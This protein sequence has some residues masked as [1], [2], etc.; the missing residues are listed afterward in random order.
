[1]ELP[2]VGIP[3]V[4]HPCQKLGSA[5]LGNENT[6]QQQQVENLTRGEREEH[7]RD[8]LILG[9]LLGILIRLIYRN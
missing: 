5:G 1:M 2:G 6:A 7:I 3:V 8:T 9:V 4:L